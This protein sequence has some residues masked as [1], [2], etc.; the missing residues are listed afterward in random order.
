MGIEGLR[1]LAMLMICVLHVNLQTKAIFDRSQMP[2]YLFSS[3]TETFCLMAVNLYAMVTGY[4]MVDKSWRFK[5]FISLELHVLFWSILFYL[6]FAACG[7]CTLWG[8]NGAIPN[9]F[10]PEY[11]YVNAYIALFFFIPF[12]NRLCNALDRRQYVIFASLLIFYTV[13]ARFQIGLGHNVEFLMICYILGGFF[14]KHPCRVS[15]LACLGGAVLLC[16][17]GAIRGALT[18][19]SIIGYADIR[20]ILPS[21]LLFCAATNI[22]RLPKRIE[23]WVNTVAPLTFGV[24]LIHCHPCVRRMMRQISPSF[25]EQSA[26]PIATLLAM[27]V[28]VFTACAAMDWVRMKLFA[29]VHTN[30]IATEISEPLER[31]FTKIIT[32]L[33]F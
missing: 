14:K 20:V 2:T 12:L 25:L 29:S 9:M 31:L 15:P 6:T 19:C 27:Y 17:P 23:P 28:L 10:Y 4:V 32:K 11:W 7:K 26:Y 18:G 3:F 16:I 24:Y 21:L 1:I 13:T 30:R 5:R 22:P 33:G 8:G